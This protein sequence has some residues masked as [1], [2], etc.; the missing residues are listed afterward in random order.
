MG[1]TVNTASSKL[2]YLEP[3]NNKVSDYLI[4]TFNSNGTAFTVSNT[5]NTNGMF[6]LWGTNYIQT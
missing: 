5:H 4:G 2:L 3:E 1:N 6:V